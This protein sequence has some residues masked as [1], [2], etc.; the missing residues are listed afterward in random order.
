MAQPSQTWTGWMP[1]LRGPLGRGSREAVFISVSALALYLGLALFSYHPGDPSWSHSAH[2]ES[3][4][5]RGGVV[6]AWLADILLYLFGIMAYLFPFMVAYAGW[7]VSRS[8]RRLRD[9][10]EG[11]HWTTRVAGGIATLG[12]GCALATLH[13][14]GYT[15]LPV[16]AGGIAGNLLGGSLAE[17]FSPLGATVFLLALFLTGFTLFTGLSWLTVMDLI[18]GFTLNALGLVAGVVRRSGSLLQAYR[19]RHKRARSAA[20]RRCARAAGRLPESS[21]PFRR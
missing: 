5:N 6:G 20:R 2:V 8:S 21:R 4:A 14:H 16:D 9:S 7:M 12:A 10:S 19:A 17:A 18:G 11:I 3:I 15:G 1:W 13:Y